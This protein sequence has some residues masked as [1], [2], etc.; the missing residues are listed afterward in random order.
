MKSNENAELIN[1]TP[2]QLSGPRLKKSE[3]MLIIPPFPNETKGLALPNLNNILNNVNEFNAE[4]PKLNKHLLHEKNK[5]NLNLNNIQLENF[6]KQKK[7]NQRIF[8]ISILEKVEELSK[9][10]NLIQKE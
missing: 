8:S 3:K 9:G 7:K 10:E 2:Q 4:S 1:K 5:K 6:E